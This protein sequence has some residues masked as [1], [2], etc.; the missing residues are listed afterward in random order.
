MKRDRARLVQFITGEN[1][2]QAPYFTLALTHSFK[3]SFFNSVMELRAAYISI[4]T[5]TLIASHRQNA[6]FLFDY[7]KAC[8]SLLQTVFFVCLCVLTR[9][10]L[11]IALLCVTTSKFPTSTRPLLTEAR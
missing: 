7:R 9:S 1:N 4:F 3:S 11:R 5:G 8:Q 10:L 6:V 2:S